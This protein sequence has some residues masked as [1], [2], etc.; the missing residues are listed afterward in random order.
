MGRF[1]ATSFQVLGHAKTI[2]VLFGGWA[3][4]REA[5]NVRQLSGMSLAI[6]GMILYGYFISKGG[7]AM[8]STP[9]SPGPAKSEEEGLA[10]LLPK[11]K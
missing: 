2:L 9:A 4:F 11:H 10:G 7:K 5:I 3:I 6:L 1:S 8:A